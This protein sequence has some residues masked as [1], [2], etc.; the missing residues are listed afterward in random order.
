[1]AGVDEG[2]MGSEVAQNDIG[3]A[4]PQHRRDLRDFATRSQAV[5]A[6]RKRLS[7][8]WRDRVRAPL[9]AAL[10]KQARH[11]LDEQ[12]HAARALANALDHLR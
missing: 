9:F 2:R 6:C 4:P 3:K 8:S 7:Q 10:E 12:W 11:L 5:E 1:M